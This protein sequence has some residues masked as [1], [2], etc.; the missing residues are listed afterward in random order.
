MPQHFAVII[1]GGKGERFW[2]QSRECR[3]K[4]LL[5]IVGKKP[6]LA[7]TLDRIRPVVPAKNTFVITSAAQEKAVRQVCPK[8]PGANIIAEPFGRDTAPATALAAALVGARDPQGV[9]AMLPADHVIPDAK[10]YRRDLCA[11][12]AAASAG[13]VMVT[14]GIKPT[15]PETGFG[16]IHMGGAWREFDGAKFARVKQFKEKPALDLARHYVASGEYAWNAG[17]FVWSVPVVQT[18]FEKHAPAYAAAFEPVRKAF[19]KR[20]PVGAA[21]KKI[22]PKL[23]RLSVDYA[24][25]EKADNVVVLPASFKW[26]DVGSWPAV[27]GH[28][29][30]D[31]NGNALRG[32]ALVVQGC[33][34]IVFSEG[35]HLTA[36]LGLDDVVVVHTKD[37]TLVVPKSKAQEIKKVIAKIGALKNGKKWL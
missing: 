32:D 27:Q 24:L 30:L 16:Y 14:I 36:V 29:A 22:Y 11:A 4:H 8:L 34:N 6:M 10:A 31:A 7:R 9:F 26:D 5:P 3:P 20:K 2:P 21:L 33:G 15:R 12:F 28:C 18:A 13:P 1:A 17:M 23:D 25:L 35:G 37:A 19:A